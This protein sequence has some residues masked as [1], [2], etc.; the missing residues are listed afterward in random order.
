MK[1]IWKIEGG[2]LLRFVTR[3]GKVPLQDIVKVRSGARR[4]NLH[5]FAYAA[6]LAHEEGSKTDFP[7]V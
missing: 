1:K 2:A 5:G 7:L 4:R 3:P 6:W